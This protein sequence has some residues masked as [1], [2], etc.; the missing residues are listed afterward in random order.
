MREKNKTLLVGV[1]TLAF[2]AGSNLASAQD[3]GKDQG[4]K[5]SLGASSSQ[6]PPTQS[7]K[8][9]KGGASQPAQ[10]YNS[11]SPQGINRTDNQSAE[12]AKNATAKR[13]DRVP[14]QSGRSAQQTDQSKSGAT[15]QRPQEHS[16][17]A[18][19]ERRGHNG[20]LKG[21]R[22]ILRFQCK[23]RTFISATVSELPFATLLLMTG[24]PRAWAMSILA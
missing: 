7:M 22:A 18:S 23:A 5:S 8:G 4:G 12:G 3:I 2:I 10:S 1:A 15:A 20:N 24:L 16:K 9:D 14:D 11:A 6:T 13:N 21:L 17:A 19:E